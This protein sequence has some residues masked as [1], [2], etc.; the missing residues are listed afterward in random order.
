MTKQR[1]FRDKALQQYI[2]GK[3]KTILPRFASPPVFVFLWIL[4]GLLL[5][6]SIAAWL[7][8]VPTFVSGSG[9]ISTPTG[10]TQQGGNEAFA[11]I[12]IPATA[13]LKLHSGLPVQVQIGS[14]GPRVLGTITTVAADVT[15]PAAARKQY[16]LSG[17]LTAVITQPS[18]VVTASLGTTISPQL[19]ASSTVTAQIQVGTQRVLSLFPGFGAPNGGE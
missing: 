7:A 4:L 1:I 8:Q 14:T 13:L 19:Y 18:F 6:A 2:Q 12:F 5:I 11:V 15:S 9:I 17:G 10:T 3:N 16:N